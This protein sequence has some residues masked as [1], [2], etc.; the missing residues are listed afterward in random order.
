MHHVLKSIWL[1]RIFLPLPHVHPPRDGWGG[2]CHQM[3]VP[4][5]PGGDGHH[6]TVT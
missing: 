5:T 1:S 4:P 6:T 2:A 3:T